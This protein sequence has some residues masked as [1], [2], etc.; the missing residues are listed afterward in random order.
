MTY[1]IVEV[2]ECTRLRRWVH[3]VE[4]SSPE[5]AIANVNAGLADL[6]GD[7]EMGRTLGDEDFGR[8]GF[9]VL[10]GDT[11][12]HADAATKECIENLRDAAY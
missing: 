9:A 5:E 7:H 6:S 4:A 1:T 12:E 10:A 3:V 8:S 11:S 2:Q